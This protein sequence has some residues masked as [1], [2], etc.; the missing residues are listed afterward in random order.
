MKTPRP[1]RALAL[2]VLAASL[3]SWVAPAS[4]ARAAHRAREAVAPERWVTLRPSLVSR[5]EVSAALVGQTVYV[6]GGFGSDAR[7]SATVEQFDVVSGRWSHGVPLPRPLNHMSA[8]SYGGSLYV[9]GGYAQTGDT[10]AGAVRDFWRF[11]PATHRWSAMPRAPIA[12]AAAGAAVLGNRLYVAGG[13]SDTMTTI[14]STAI[15]DF[16]TGRWSLGPPLH[17]AREHVAAVAAAGAVWLLGGRALG[18]GNFADVER[19]RPGAH[20][21][22]RMPPMPLARSSFQA[23]AAA[24]KIVIVG[25]EDSSS[26]FGRVDAFDPAHRRWLRLPDLPAPRHGLGLVANGP[27]VYAIEGAPRAGLTTSNTVQ[28]LR[29]R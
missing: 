29:V 13:R 17:H 3:A 12:R 14:S 8:A 18:Q 5:C 22:Q 24:G 1:S 15:F 9:V 10:S 26:T 2:L 20:A 21:W 11:D 19:L 23:V 7:T 16:S 25:G 4:A 28:L 6:V 27:Y